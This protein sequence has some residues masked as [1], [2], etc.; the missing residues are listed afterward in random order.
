MPVTALGTPAGEAARPS[1][2]YVLRSD[3]LCEL[4]PASLAGLRVP[5]ERLLVSP[6][7]REGGFTY[8]S[9]FTGN[10]VVFKGSAAESRSDDE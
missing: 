1:G 8:T 6:P 3:V 9:L 2:K 10:E 4:D 7:Y 5:L